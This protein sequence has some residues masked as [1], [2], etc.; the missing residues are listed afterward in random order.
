MTSGRLAG[1]G[2]SCDLQCHASGSKP[3][4]DSSPAQDFWT[5]AASR[6][7]PCLW[8]LSSGGATCRAAG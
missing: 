5:L 3:S 1:A 7:R 2:G 6:W 4:T 8:T